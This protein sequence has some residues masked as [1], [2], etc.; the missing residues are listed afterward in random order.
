MSSPRL[1]RQLDFLLEID[2][3]KT[4]E[5]QTLLTDRSRRENSAEHSWHIALMAVLLSEYS[6][7][8][9]LDLF[10]VIRMLLVHDIVEID[11]GDTFCYDEAGHRDKEERERR[12]AERLFGLLPEDQG[13]DLRR[14][15]DEFEARETPE[16]HFANA[17]DRLQPLLHNVHTEG[18]SWR[19]HGV[20]S[21][22]VLERNSPIGEGAPE[23]W[24]HARRLIE[25]AVG[26][27]WLAE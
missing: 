19:A 24:E 27:G 12:A 13:A 17:L 3:L 9:R 15:W 4:I 11:A 20:R 7:G 5:R 10:R 26:R 8:S 2:R 18:A 25:E 22:Q 16:A 21:H 6:N 14:L 23:L 1:Q